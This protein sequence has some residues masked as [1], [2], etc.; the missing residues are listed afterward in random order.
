METY[1]ALTKD[2]QLALE[3]LKATGEIQRIAR[4]D[5]T[6]SLGDLH[7]Y[8]QDLTRHLEFSQKRR[9]GDYI[10]VTGQQE[11]VVV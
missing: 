10:D 3:M 4:P 7:Q 11:E 5:G 9:K 1:A 8:F 6:V 2:E